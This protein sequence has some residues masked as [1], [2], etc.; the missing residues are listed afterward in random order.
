MKLFPHWMRQDE[1]EIIDGLIYA[2]LN[3]GHMISVYDSQ[4]L[5]LKQS[6]DYDKICA[7]VCQTEWTEFVVWDANGNRLGWFWLIHGNGRDV[8]SDY[9]DN[10][11]CDQIWKEIEPL[12]EGEWVA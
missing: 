6:R 4:E 5:I 10:A 9:T 11:Y 3:R 1:K 2:I 8:V 7:E 12:T